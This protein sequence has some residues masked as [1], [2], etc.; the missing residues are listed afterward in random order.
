MNTKRQYTSSLLTDT[1]QIQK[2]EPYYIKECASL[3]TKIL[4]NDNCKP[5]M[6]VLELNNPLYKYY[7]SINPDPISFS[8]VLFR[9]YY[10]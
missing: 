3:L 4:W 8:Y 2:Q 1:K 9:I 6:K 5:F 7:K 10:N